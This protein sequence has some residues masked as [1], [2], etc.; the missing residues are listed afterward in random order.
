MEKLGM[1]TLGKEQSEQRQITKQE[2]ENL[3]ESI[4]KECEAA[5]NELKIHEMAKDTNRYWHL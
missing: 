2:G 1:Q 3:K 5:A 4:R